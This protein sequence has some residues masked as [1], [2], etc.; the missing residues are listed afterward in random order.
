MISRR[1]RVVITLMIAILAITSCKEQHSKGSSTGAM[2]FAQ[3][4]HDFADNNDEKG[5]TL[6]LT[7]DQPIL[8]REIVMKTGTVNWD[9]GKPN[10]NNVF[11]WN[12]V[13]N[14][15]RESVNIEFRSDSL[16]TSVEPKL[17]DYPDTY[18]YDW[19]AYEKDINKFRREI[20]KY[21]SSMLGKFMNAL[22]AGGTVTF[23]LRGKIKNVTVTIS[24]SDIDSILEIWNVYQQM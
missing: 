6:T 16:S 8:V 5:M 12:Q 11:S 14:G 7:L 2:L 1:M 15:V 19:K 20:E 10:Y 18:G 9:L 22:K 21:Q 24:K 23:E 4:N 3:A 13:G 17:E